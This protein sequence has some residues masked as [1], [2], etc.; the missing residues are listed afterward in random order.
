[1]KLLK[2]IAWSLVLGSTVYTPV[3]ANFITVIPFSDPLTLAETFAGPGITVCNATY[4]GSAMSAGKYHNSSSEAQGNN[5]LKS[6]IV[7]SSGMVS[8]LNSAGDN[9]DGF[10]SGDMSG[11]N[12][13][14]LDSLSGYPTFD[15]S[16]LEFDFIVD[17]NPGEL[18]T[19]S[20]WYVFGSDEYEEFVGTFFNDV[21]GFFLDGVNIATIPGT[22]TPISI[23]T[24]NPELNSYLYNRNTSDELFSEIDGFTIPLYAQFSVNAGERHHLKLAIADGTDVFGD[25]WLLLGEDSFTNTPVNVPEPSISTFFVISLFFLLIILLRKKPV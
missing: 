19:S 25:T 11:S 22:D 17:G 6:G 16:I 1:M 7:L 18:V 14:D 15:A 13:S 12:D 20:F 5:L 3:S 9:T 23:N 8:S 24:I 21:F 4:E 10:T 2:I